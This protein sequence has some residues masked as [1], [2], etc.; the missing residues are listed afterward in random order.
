MAGAEPVRI[1]VALPDGAV[2]TVL[3]VDLPPGS[4]ALDALRACGADPDN[5]ALGVFGRSVEADTPLAD[6]DRL[7]VYPP[8]RVDPKTARQRRALATRKNRTRR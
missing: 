7:E 5:M 6:G 1:E 4:T 8:L 2:Y 3:G